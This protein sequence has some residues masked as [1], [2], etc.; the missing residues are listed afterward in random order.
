MKTD[1]AINKNKEKKNIAQRIAAILY[2]TLL[3][4]Q[5]VSKSSIN[6]LLLCFQITSNA[7]LNSPRPGDDGAAH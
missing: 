1:Q 4:F 6:K 2:Q 5:N 7:H 3:L